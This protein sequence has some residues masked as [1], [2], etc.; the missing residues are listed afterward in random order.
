MKLPRPSLLEILSTWESLSTKSSRRSMTSNPTRMW[1][2]EVAEF[3][4]LLD[5]NILPDLLRN[6]GGRVF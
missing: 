5:T 3:W 2:S 4:Y 6:P 1:I